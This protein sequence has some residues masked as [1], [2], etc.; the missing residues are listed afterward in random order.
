MGGGGGVA[1]E[2]SRADVRSRVIA[3][4]AYDDHPTVMQMFD[5]GAAAYLLQG[6]TVETLIEG[7]SQ[8]A[9]GLQA[10]GDGI[11]P[12]SRRGR[13]VARRT[14]R[15]APPWSRS[16]RVCCSSTTTRISCGS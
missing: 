10:V 3:L 9:Q 2:L 6:S 15:G 14:R 13:I 12:G 5:A 7:I 16:R 1:R 4:S 8:A 11:A